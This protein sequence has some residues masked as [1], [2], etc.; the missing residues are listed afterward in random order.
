MEVFSPASITAAALIAIGIVTWMRVRSRYRLNAKGIEALRAGRVDEAE[1]CFVRLVKFSGSNDLL[2]RFN[3]ASVRARRGLFA[4]AAAEY[5]RIRTVLEADR[6]GVNV[7]FASQAGLEQARCMAILGRTE[8]I[9]RLIEEISREQDGDW[10]RRSTIPLALVR[11]RQGRFAEALQILD[12]GWDACLDS[13]PRSQ[14]MW[15]L[16]LRAYALTR[17]GCLDNAAADDALRRLEEVDRQLLRA[18]AS[19]WPEFDR[20][21]KRFHAFFEKSASQTA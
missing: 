3:L 8:G 9:D 2:P 5:E 10:L 12:E 17:G 19:A 20:F 6:R 15:P 21:L 18:V 16:I 13:L 4:E 7:K 1:Q 11:N 14:W